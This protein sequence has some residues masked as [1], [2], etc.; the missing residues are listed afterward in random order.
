MSGTGETELMQN[1]FQCSYHDILSF[2]VSHFHLLG[3]FFIIRGISLL[4]SGVVLY[5]YMC[6]TLITGWLG[7]MPGVLLLI[8]V[9]APRHLKCPMANHLGGST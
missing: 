1:H 5:N 9:V 8:I 2:Q 3:Y 7:V 4:L 6:L